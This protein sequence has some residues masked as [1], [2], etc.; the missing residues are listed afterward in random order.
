MKL[1]NLYRITIM[2]S[3]HQSMVYVLDIP[4]LTLV[5][6]IFNKH[7]PELLGGFTMKMI[8][9]DTPKD[10]V[11]ECLRLLAGGVKPTK[12]E[13]RAIIV[14]GKFGIILGPI[15]RG[16]P[17][18]S[19]LT[20]YELLNCLLEY[21]RN[22]EKIQF[23]CRLTEIEKLVRV[24]PFD[25]SVPDIIIN[26]TLARQACLKEVKYALKASLTEFLNPNDT[27]Y[28]ATCV[29][30]K[31]MQ[32]TILLH[33]EL[34]RLLTNRTLKLK[35]KGSRSLGFTLRSIVND[36]TFKK[37]GVGGDNDVE[38]ILHDEHMTEP[39]YNEI[40]NKI[41]KIQRQ[42][43]VKHLDFM[44]DIVR[45][46]FIGSQAWIGQQALIRDITFV[47]SKSI[48]SKKFGDNTSYVKYL[49]T[50]KKIVHY[51]EQITKI[52]E[53]FELNIF[54]LGRV[55]CKFEVSLWNYPTPILAKA[56]ILDLAFRLFNDSSRITNFKK[57]QNVKDIEITF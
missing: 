26:E 17:K 37:Y 33:N 23:N 43:V 20:L 42:I 6:D 24:D 19:T 56:E 12:N 41:M 46:N 51:T 32:E 40:M 38:F 1:V 5:M 22:T 44:C 7:C 9:Y 31:D 36:G 35:L 57:M 10:G 28:L 50:E 45:S 25:S 13:E 48:V 53:D 11:E 34:G 3:E 30:L 39:E 15:V 21:S 4:L 29:V 55:M 8:Y 16:T 2:D 47:E 49:T 18:K 27:L 14:A 54:N 52:E